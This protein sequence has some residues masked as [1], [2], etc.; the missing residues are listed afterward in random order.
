MVPRVARLA[1]MSIPEALIL[2]GLWMAFV[3]NAHRSE[4]IAGV[5]AALIAA[6]ADGV[7]KSR[8][9]VEFFP[10]FSWLALILLEPWYALEGTWEIFVALAEHM[11]GKP[12]KAELKSVPFDPGGDDDVSQAR[13]AIAATYFTIPPNFIVLGIDRDRAR[14]LVHQ[15]SPTGVPVIAKKLGAHE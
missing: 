4:M 3:S 14:I 13:R 7:V 2:W 12:S 15:V 5:A 11:L 6:V 10:R 8:R 9:L 1:L